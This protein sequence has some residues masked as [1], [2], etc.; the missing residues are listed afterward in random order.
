MSDHSTIET[1]KLGRCLVGSTIS[2]FANLALT[3][4]ESDVLDGVA[5]SI[6]VENG[7]PPS[8]Y[9]LSLKKPLWKALSA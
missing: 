5:T 1:L 8:L 6:N 2:R 3:R 9:I 4:R 7:A